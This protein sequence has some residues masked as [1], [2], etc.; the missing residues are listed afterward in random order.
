[1]GRPAN[2]NCH[3]SGPP[4]WIPYQ[5]RVDCVG[6]VSSGATVSGHT[7]DWVFDKITGG[8]FRWVQ[9]WWGPHWC[10]YDRSNTPGSPT[11]PATRKMKPIR[12]SLTNWQSSDFI[13]IGDD[14]MFF[15]APSRL[16]KTNLAPPATSDGH[17]SGSRISAVV[18][19]Q[20]LLTGNA[21][22]S[23]SRIVAGR[24]LVN[25]VDVSGIVSLNVTFTSQFTQSRYK[26]YGVQAS[27][28][29]TISLPSTVSLSGGETIEI[30]LWVEFIV[31]KDP[32]SFNPSLRPTRDD[33]LWS[34]LLGNGSFGL[35]CP[36]MG[37]HG[38]HELYER[39]SP[40]FFTATPA[41]TPGEINAQRRLRDSDTW[42]LTFS[43]TTFA[44][45]SSLVLQAQS[46]WEFAR[47]SG[48][49]V[50]TQIPGSPLPPGTSPN[51]VEFRYDTETP[52]IRIQTTTGHSG[53]GGL[54]VRYLAPSPSYFDAHT[55]W[56]DANGP[57]TATGTNTFTPSIVNFRS[58]SGAWQWWPFEYA[59]SL[60]TDLSGYPTSITA[61]R[62]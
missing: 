5:R 3:C 2:C 1:M 19:E 35:W 40:F 49:I 44:G 27:R 28:A 15:N 41:V 58:S 21:D 23:P 47:Q 46:G 33:T 24:V 18:I 60:G 17:F 57:V 29:F 50:M 12:W 20:G 52:E 32:T 16:Q 38:T 55:T 7:V 43:G 31:V 26:G 11:F 61:V 45:V 36:M 25:S 56:Q 53:G 14:H 42:T 39:T 6:P 51:R 30:D 59:E 48:M 54:G 22:I 10:Y 34:T 13:W 37:A 62:A 9:A 4:L 8:N